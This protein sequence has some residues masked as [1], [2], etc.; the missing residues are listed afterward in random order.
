MSTA[1]VSV[2]VDLSLK[3]TGI[4]AVCGATS[5]YPKGQGP[6]VLRRVVIKVE[7]LRGL[8]RLAVV[9]A[10]VQ[11]FAEWLHGRVLTPRVYMF[12]GPAFGAQ[13]AHK[14]GQVHGVVK[15]GLARRADAHAFD[16]AD[17]PPL[18]LKKWAADDGH[19]EKNA[20]MLKTFQ[21]WGFESTDDNECDAY[22]AALAGLAVYGPMSPASAK[23]LAKKISVYEKQEGSDRIVPMTITLE[24]AP[25][26]TR[27][28]RIA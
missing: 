10:A 7:H 19:A 26:K 16:L 9:D 20:M 8:H 13:I 25:A 4:V 17:I 23:E 12:E 21:R 24:S 27:R 2:G 3:A 18:A 22:C 11:E 14:L 28:R 5:A 15:L 1:I 6:Q